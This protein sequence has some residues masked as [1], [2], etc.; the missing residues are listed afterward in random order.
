MCLVLIAWIQ[1]CLVPYQVFYNLVGVFFV[2]SVL[3]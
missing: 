1:Y 3:A 2:R